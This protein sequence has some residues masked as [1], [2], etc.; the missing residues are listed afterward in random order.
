MI[1][2]DKTFIQRIPK[3][4]TASFISQNVSN[5]NNLNKRKVMLV[6][7]NVSDIKMLVPG[8]VSTI[9]VFILKVKSLHIKVIRGYYWKCFV[10]PKNG[11]RLCVIRV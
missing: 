7:L 3:F 1:G 2:G 8:F 9:A 11:L 5:L 6:C 10:S 4:V